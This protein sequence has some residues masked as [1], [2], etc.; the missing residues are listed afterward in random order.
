MMIT[1]SADGFQEI[2]AAQVGERFRLINERRTES[3]GVAGGS[4]R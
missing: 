1:V 3:R 2:A 4:L